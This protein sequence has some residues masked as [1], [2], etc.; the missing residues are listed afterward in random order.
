MENEVSRGNLAGNKGL[1]NSPDVIRSEFD[2]AE[3][4]T[5]DTL[6]D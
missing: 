3:K 4:V 5:Q 2:Y 1:E 6:T